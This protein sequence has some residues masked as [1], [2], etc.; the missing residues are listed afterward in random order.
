MVLFLI[1]SLIIIIWI[2]LPAIIR[3]KMWKELAVYAV[4]MA[5]GIIYGLGLI[6]NW[7]LPNPYRL[8]LQSATK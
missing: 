2:D 6:Y 7:P 8:F 4:L 3:K 5:T 1:A